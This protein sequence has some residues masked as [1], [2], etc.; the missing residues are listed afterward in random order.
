M[1]YFA[2]G[3]NLDWEQ[4]KERCS[5]ARFVC[6]AVLRDHK[7]AFT[8]KSINRGCGA[9]DVIPDSGKEVWGVVYQISDR[10]VGKLDKAE[11]FQ[12]GRAK[13]SYM[14]EERHVFEEGKAE[15][16]VNVTI[17]LAVK[18]ENPP[19]PDK[20]Y[21]DQI[22]NGAKYWH[23]PEGYIEELEGIKVK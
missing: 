21:K 7:L 4:M 1:L 3:S 5:T 22:V 9:A 23:L 11:G 15:Q 20:K 12:P 19:L 18:E 17:Y 6:N 13:N 2:Y 10:D 14:R 16:P 8:R